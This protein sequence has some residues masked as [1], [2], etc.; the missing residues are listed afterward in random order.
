M[1]GQPANARRGDVAYFVLLGILALVYTA[2]RYTFNPEFDASFYQK[3]YDLVAPV[4]FGKRIL[5]AL[6]ARPLAGGGLSVAR[7]FQA[8]E[9]ISTFCLF[10]GLYRVFGLQV[11]KSWARVL[12]A[13][14]ALILPLV[15]LLRNP[16]PYRFPWDTPAM[17]FIAWGTFFL[18]RGQWVRTAILMIVAT[19][20]R[21]S[22]VLIPLLFGVMY[23]DRLPLRKLLL[24]GATLL[25]VYATVSWLVS[26]TLG[27]NLSYYG[28][29][30]MA[31][32][33]K[34]GKWRLFINLA[35]LNFS[36][37]NYLVLL[38]TLGGLP[39]VFLAF[40]RW[41]PAH[42]RGFGLVALFYFELLA[43][44][45]N[46]Y[47]SRIFGEIVTLLYIPAALGGGRYLRAGSPPDEFQLPGQAN[48]W[49]PHRTRLEIAAV[50]V[51]LGL[52]IA[53]GLVLKAI[54]APY[55]P[56]VPL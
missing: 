44:V 53:G 56:P 24:V 48:H 25:A 37:R 22:A 17:A 21:E 52:L 46:L 23:F 31:S 34:Y 32:L 54:P 51:L 38:A 26:L 27:D 47:E 35:W 7:A 5:M 36:I 49:H 9:V 19:L 20:N 28:P 14:F 55:T 10:A 16:F 30:A 13:G 12:G 18:L 43:C 42:L 2:L 15:F 50:A 4:P 33:H 8:W 41:I 29:N 11:E 3:I 1:T 6:L 40:L 39:L 45:G